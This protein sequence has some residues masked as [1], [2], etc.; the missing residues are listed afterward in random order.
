MR[1]AQEPEPEAGWGSRTLNRFQ[2]RAQAIS[3]GASCLLS[4][5][6]F[7]LLF[8][9]MQIYRLHLA[10]SQLMTVFGGFLGSFLFL[11]ALTA[12]GNLESYAFGKGFQTKLFP[13]VLISLLVAVFASGLIHRVCITTCFLFTIVALYYMNKISTKVH[14]TAP[15]ASVVNSVPERK[16]RK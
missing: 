7:V 8:A 4:T 1:W 2:A 13:E 9:S 12:I 11:L 10:S 6:L 5:T 16:R 3:T 15:S 14:G